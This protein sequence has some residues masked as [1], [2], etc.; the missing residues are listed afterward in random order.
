MHNPN[1]EKKKFHSTQIYLCGTSHPIPKRVCFVLIGRFYYSMHFPVKEN[2][3]ADAV[4]FDTMML[5]KMLGGETTAEVVTLHRNRARAKQ[6][7]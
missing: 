6:A 4:I 1:E 7:R 5:S 3:R 2:E